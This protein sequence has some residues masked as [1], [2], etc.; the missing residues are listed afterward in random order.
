MSDENND[1]DDF[2]NPE[3]KDFLGDISKGVQDFANNLF[4]EE[5]SKQINEFAE[6]TVKTM[7]DFND[8]LLKS[9]NLTDNELVKKFSDGSKDLLKQMGL[10][11]EETEDDF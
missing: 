7:V 3:K 10:L 8:E 11:Q 2:E 1:F 5:T 9:L 6:K 4:G